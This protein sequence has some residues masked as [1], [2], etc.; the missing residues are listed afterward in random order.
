MT[1]ILVILSFKNVYWVYTS[2]LEPD[3]MKDGQ[4]PDSTRNKNTNM[5]QIKPG[6]IRVLSATYSEFQAGL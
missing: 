6:I 2:R 1:R 5:V 4:K 3:R